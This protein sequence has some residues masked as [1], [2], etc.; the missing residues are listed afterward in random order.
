M[1]S[2]LAE[3]RDHSKS[4]EP[5]SA[6]PGSCCLEPRAFCRH[7]APSGAALAR[8]QPG[9][10]VP[11]SSGEQQEL[12]SRVPQSSGGQQ[13]FLSLPAEADESR[14]E[15]LSASTSS[16]NG[17]GMGLPGAA[18]GDPEPPGQRADLGQGLGRAQGQSSQPRAS[19]GELWL[20]FL[21]RQQQQQGWGREGQLSLVER[22]E[23]LARLLQSPIRHSL[24]LQGVQKMQGVQG[25]EQPGVALAGKARAGSSTEPQGAQG[26]ERA[27][28]SH[29]KN[30][31]EEPRAHRAGHRVA[32]HLE[33]VLE[34]PRTDR[35]GHRVAQQLDRTL[36]ELKT[37]R[38]RHRVAQQLDRAL[39]ELREQRAGH[40]VTQ[41]LDREQQHVA[42]PSDGSSETRLSEEPS[43]CSTSG[44]DTGTLAG[45][46][47]SPASGDSSSLSLSTI[48]TARLLRAFGHHRLGLAPQLSPKM[49]PKLSPKLAQL[50]GA[51]RQQR[52]RS[53]KRDEESAAAS[54]GCAL[55]AAESPGE[56]QS[57]VRAHLNQP[58]L[59][60]ASWG[61]LKTSLYLYYIYI[62]IFIYVFISIYVLYLY[63]YVYLFLYI[64]SYI[65]LYFYIFIA[66]RAIPG[67]FFFSPPVPLGAATWQ[68]V[69][70]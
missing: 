1:F 56:G 59:G 21:Q 60:P 14:Q 4:V 64:Y 15:E 36:E 24:G 70:K 49:S 3:L 42:V 67:V 27:W 17:A 18:G 65:C 2:S 53:E 28:E 48:D 38:Q 32:Q 54:G 6:V 8:A 45:P 41:Q 40:R 7:R 69:Q 39:E 26:G 63:L 62:C 66:A 10:C 25:R 33:R 23:R 58:Q 34:E 44:W 22:L 9:P 31:L 57:Q 29:G 46:D 47:T 11:Q 35:Q 68:Q 50:Y 52:R 30:S 61:L 43:T 13:E 19:L 5:S 37:D 51:I 55:G 20:R 16:G 12:F